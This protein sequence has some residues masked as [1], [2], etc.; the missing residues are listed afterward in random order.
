MTGTRPIRTGLVGLGNSGWYY[1]AEAHLSPS[2]RFEVAAV[3]S[4]DAARAQA[5]ADRFGARPY[6]DWRDL[7]AADDV[8]LVVIALPH[9]L[10]R[11]VAVAAA[12]AGKHV[13]VEKPMAVTTRDADEMIAA[14]AAAGVVLSVFQ[15]RRWEQDVQV[16]R[17]LIDDGVVGD[18]WHV[19]VA[20]SHAGRY[21]TVGADRPHAG[22][23]VLPWPHQR[24]AG[25]GIAWVIGPHPVDALLH[26]VDAAPTAVS[27][28]VHREPGDEVEHF[29][30]VDV[31]FDDGAGGRVSVFRRSGIAPPRFVVY[32]TKATLMASDG[33]EVLVQPVDGERRRITGLRPPSVEGRPVYDGLYDAIRHGAPPAVTA[34][35]GRAAVHVLELAL[36]SAA[37]GGV[38]LPTTAPAAR[39]TSS[40]A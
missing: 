18:V 25:G 31:T 30:A 10:H 16:L 34:E 2:D 33:T 22:D 6:T 14:A 29:L 21:R 20:R 26:L 11:D 24:A 37:H 13:L 36:Q 27:G 4:R 8:E 39:A 35:E 19:E 3:C 32:G 7:V 23:A 40:G 38:P 17:G 5:A 15:Q 1:H 12:G 9:H 28:R